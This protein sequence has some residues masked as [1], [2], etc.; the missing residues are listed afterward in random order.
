MPKRLEACEKRIKTLMEEAG[1]KRVKGKTCASYL[2]HLKEGAI[3]AAYAH[4]AV[5]LWPDGNEN[6]EALIE[7]MN[8]NSEEAICFLFMLREGNIIRLWDHLLCDVIRRWRED[9]D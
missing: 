8:K 1:I 5:F 9:N 7:R 4:G 3:V 2:K 6:Y